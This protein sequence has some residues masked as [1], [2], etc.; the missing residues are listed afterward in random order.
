MEPFRS[1]FEGMTL[2]DAF[3]AAARGH[4]DG[5]PVVEDAVG[6]SLAYGRLMT[7]AAVLARKFARLTE[8]G[9]YVAVML[10][11][12]NAVVLTFLGLQSA[13]RIPAMLN[14]TAGPAVVVSACQTVKA[15]RVISSRAFV[16]KAELQPLVSALESAGLQM[17][18]LEDIAKT[19]TGIDKAIG[20]VMRNSVL[21]KSRP[22]DPALVLFTSGS[23]GLPK[24]VVLSHANIL[25]NCAQ[26]ER[27]VEFS[28]KDKLFN[29]LPVF[30]S[31]GLTGGMILPLVNG[32]RLYL[33]PSPLHYKII[34]QAI[35]RTR[36]TILFGTDTFLTGYARTAKD[37]DFETLRLVVAGAE[38]VRKDTHETWKHRFDTMVLEG[39][40]MTEAAPVVAVNAPQ[41]NRVGSVGQLLAGMEHRIEPVEGIDSGGKLWVKGPNV[42][43]GYML[44]ENPGVLVRPQDGWHD[45]GDIVDIDEQGFITIKGRVKRFAKIAGEMVSLGAVE[46]IAQNLWPEDNHAVV[47]VPDKRKGERVVLVTTAGEATRDSLADASKKSGYTELYVPNSIVHVPQVPVL[48]TGK[49]D[50]TT[51]RK[52]AIGKLG[53]DEAA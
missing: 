31:L 14:Y 52:I 23:E 32:V 8:R 26:I 53:L 33:Y 5:K 45:S 34:P 6:G 50:Y 7:G 11:N 46:I 41:T 29:A 38:A 51:V 43:L 15:R 22:D 4:D 19:V 16:E 47:A 44:A 17:L 27:R 10:P 12:A 9:E 39:F 36:A 48:G 28:S 13:A 37:S 21:Q 25:A 49:T 3:V 24:G 20:W 18:W 40:G 35:A 42:M 1:R 30:H 2:F